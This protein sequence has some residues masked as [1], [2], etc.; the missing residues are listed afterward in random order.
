MS[1]GASPAPGRRTATRPAPTRP[2]ILP[3][4]GSGW[5][6]WPL[7]ERN[8]VVYRRD[9]VVFVTGFLEPL[10]YLLSIGVGVE[11]LVGRFEL[12]NGRA[13]SYTEF[14]APA[15]LATS[16]MNGALF[17]TTFGVFFKLK[18]EKVYDGVLSTPLRP[19]DVAGG[20]LV[21]ALMRAAVYAVAFVAVMVALGLV[22]SWWALLA[23]PAAVLIGFAFGGAGMALTTWM[24]SWQDFDFITLAILPMFLFSATFFPLERYPEVLQWVVQATPLYQGVVL[25]RGLSTGVIT[26]DMAV[27]VVYLLALGS[28]GLAVASR[29]FGRLLLR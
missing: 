22:S 23:A 2:R 8:L 16:A 7:V 18:Y 6:A 17:D 29:R 12:P 3:L 13:V 4:P 11:Q 24:R 20:E 26:A 1:G 9:W 21:F 10:L 14:V 5:P 19:R 25:C 15:M 28:L 27:A